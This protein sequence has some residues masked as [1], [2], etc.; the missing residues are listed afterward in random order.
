MILIAILILI[1][2]VA[3]FEAGVLVVTL[4]IMMGTF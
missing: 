1:M 2:L 3:I 4:Q